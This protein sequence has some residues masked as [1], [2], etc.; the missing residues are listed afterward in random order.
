MVLCS[1]V[2]MC[3]PLLAAHTIYGDVCLVQTPPHREVTHVDQVA[4]LRGIGKHS[5]Q[6]IEVGPML[7]SKTHAL[8]D[9]PPPPPPPHPRS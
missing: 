7:P 2:C 4:G 6:V 5:A 9:L 3:I 1:S 8:N